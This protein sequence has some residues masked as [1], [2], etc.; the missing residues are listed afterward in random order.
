MTLDLVSDTC[1]TDTS[2]EASLYFYLVNDMNSSDDDD[3]DSP[4]VHSDIIVPVGLFL[5]PLISSCNA[6]R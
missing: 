3:D 5:C 4:S 6:S 2:T 1:D